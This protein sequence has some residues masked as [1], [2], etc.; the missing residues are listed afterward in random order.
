MNFVVS[1]QIIFH[2]EFKS[3]ELFLSVDI[4]RTSFIYAKQILKTNPSFQFQAEKRIKNK[5]YSSILKNND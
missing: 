2:I 1:A 4:L 3:C 5:K